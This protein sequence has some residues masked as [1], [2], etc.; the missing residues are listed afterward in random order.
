MENKITIPL[1]GIESV[2]AVLLD[3]ASTMPRCDTT[4]SLYP[5]FTVEKRETSPW[6]S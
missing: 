5:V 2:E 3:A 4:I 1:I 6:Q